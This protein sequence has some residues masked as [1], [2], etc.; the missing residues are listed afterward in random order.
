MSAQDYETGIIS[1][2]LKNFK[3]FISSVRRYTLDWKL[4]Y[5]FVENILEKC[6]FNTKYLRTSNRS[7]N[8]RKKC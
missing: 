5:E 6:D 7:Q 1:L 8:C 4:R 2:I 3:Y